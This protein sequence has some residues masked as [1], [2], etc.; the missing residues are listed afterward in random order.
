MKKIPKQLQDSW[1]EEYFIQTHGNQKF[2]IPQNQIDSNNDNAKETR[3]KKKKI[4]GPLDLNYK[5]LDKELGDKENVKRHEQFM[6]GRGFCFSAYTGAY[7]NKETKQNV[8]HVFDICITKIEDKIYEI[9][10][11]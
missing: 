10:R 9:F 8:F 3:R 6:L 7:L 2:A 5:I 11:A 4:Q 1:T